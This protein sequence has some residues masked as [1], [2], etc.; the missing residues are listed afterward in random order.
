MELTAIPLTTRHM[1][2]FGCTLDSP[3]FGGVLRYLFPTHSLAY[4][5]IY[6]LK[7]AKE[8]RHL[9]K[10]GAL[11]SVKPYTY[12]T[13]EVPEVIIANAPAPPQSTGH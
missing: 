2:Y 5:Q 6:S 12:G 4:P 11:P 7:L 10:H 13:N 1:Q 3:S 9:V 8:L